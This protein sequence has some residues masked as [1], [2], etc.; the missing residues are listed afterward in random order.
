MPCALNGD[1][2]IRQRCADGLACDDPDPA[3]GTGV[4]ALGAPCELMSQMCGCE[5]VC[6]IPERPCT[7][8]RASFL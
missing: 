1:L 3:H 6:R 8:A 5:H 2:F 4:T 7:C